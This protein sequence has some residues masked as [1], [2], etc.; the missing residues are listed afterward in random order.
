[1]KSCSSEDSNL[2]RRMSLSFSASD[3][4][5]SPNSSTRMDLNIATVCWFSSASSSYRKT[6]SS[7]K[8]FFNKSFNLHVV[9][10]TTTAPAGTESF[11]CIVY[12]YKW[13]K[14][15]PLH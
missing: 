5:C 12:C 6:L 15:L 7:I 4:N 3:K 8:S 9:Q 11:F 14:Y 13:D 10:V 2:S 1:M